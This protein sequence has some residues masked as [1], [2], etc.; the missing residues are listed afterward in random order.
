[1]SSIARS[2][3]RRAG[4][5]RL[6]RKL[7]GEQRYTVQLHSLFEAL[8]DER[9][10]A[11]TAELVRACVACIGAGKAERECFACTRP[12]SLDRVPTMI[13]QVEFLRLDE[14]ILAGVCNDCAALP[15]PFAAVIRGLERGLGAAD[16]RII[17]LPAPGHA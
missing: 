13:L 5:A 17:H 6:R 1:M 11:A 7:Q 12:W 2:I 10:G 15:D 8:A 3:D 9:I 16:H 14:C 4:M